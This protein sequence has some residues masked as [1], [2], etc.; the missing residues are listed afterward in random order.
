MNDKPFGAKLAG[1]FQGPDQGGIFRQ[2]VGHRAQRSFFFQSRRP[3]FLDDEG[4]SGGT[5]IAAGGA[6]NVNFPGGR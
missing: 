2:I 1:S 3:L 6:V 4:K 5:R